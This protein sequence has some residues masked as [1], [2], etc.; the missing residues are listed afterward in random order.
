MKNGELEERVTQL[1]ARSDFTQKRTRPIEFNE[2]V[3][4]SQLRISGCFYQ[5]EE[6]R[7]V[8]RR[9]N[10]IF[11]DVKI[12]RYFTQATRAFNDLNINSF[13][14]P[15]KIDLTS[16]HILN[17]L[18]TVSI[19]TENSFES[20]DIKSIPKS[21]KSFDSGFD[22]AMPDGNPAIRPK[23]ESHPET[24]SGNGV[25]KNLGIKEKVGQ[26]ADDPEPMP[27]HARTAH[28][29]AYKPE[30]TQNEHL[31]TANRNTANA[32]RQ[33]EN[34]SQWKKVLL[35]TRRMRDT[36][37]S[38]NCNHDT[39]DCCFGKIEEPGSSIATLILNSSKHGQRPIWFP[40]LR[41]AFKEYTLQ[42]AISLLI[43]MSTWD[44]CPCHEI[45]KGYTDE[46]LNGFRPCYDWT[47]HYLPI[48][49]MTNLFTTG[50]K[51][52]QHVK[53]FKPVLAKL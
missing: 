2:K 32:Q 19:N 8:N 31:D 12:K 37:K 45:T 28:Y 1:K 27:I 29:D 15:I 34:A 39:A 43:E 33:A 10:V 42:M 24:L 38:R 26:T 49:P 9:E 18:A 41:D 21:T 48:N 47:E 7:L 36:Q 22:Q 53:T 20:G 17:R 50:S 35:S 5:P 3:F 40:D 16:E 51:I 25:K 14:I 11:L 4:K 23:S 46:E 13:S 6:V 44:S 30:V 52:R